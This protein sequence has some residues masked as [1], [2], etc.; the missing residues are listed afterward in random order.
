MQF[1]VGAAA[2]F[3]SA[4]DLPLVNV[5]NPSHFW[6]DL[7][8]C[9]SYSSP[10]LH[11]PFFDTILSYTYTSLL[12]RN[13][14]VQDNEQTTA[15]ETPTHKRVLA[16]CGAQGQ[17]PPRASGQSKLQTLNGGGIYSCKINKVQCFWLTPLQLLLWLVRKGKPLACSLLLIQLVP[18]D[19]F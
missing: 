6:S 5:W 8:S 11:S 7:R 1:L 10:P 12:S 17:L 15:R 4:F 3:L 19:V 18:R 2:H 16:G 9:S 13:T 14:G